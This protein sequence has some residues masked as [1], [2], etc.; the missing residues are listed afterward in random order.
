MDKFK[1]CLGS[2]RHEDKIQADYEDAVASG[3]RGTLHSLSFTKDGRKVPIKGSVP[4]YQLK[5]LIDSLL[6]NKE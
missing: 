6:S 4:Y 2:D 3:G 1:E 5:Y